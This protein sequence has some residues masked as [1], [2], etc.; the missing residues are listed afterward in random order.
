[1]NCNKI[2]VIESGHVVDYGDPYTLIKERGPLCNLIMQLG[3]KNAEEIIK[4]AKDSELRRRASKR[5]QVSFGHRT[6]E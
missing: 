4:L 5:T 3:K 2:M 1:M 6:E